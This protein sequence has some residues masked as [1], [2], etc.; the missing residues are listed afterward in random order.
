MVFRILFELLGISRQFACKIGLVNS[1]H[2]TQEV[3][4][5]VQ[6]VFKGTLHLINTGESS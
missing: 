5:R 3:P 4:P 2:S 6:I 1:I